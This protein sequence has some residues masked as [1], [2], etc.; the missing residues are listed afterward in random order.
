[1]DNKKIVKV[2]AIVLGSLLI[3]GIGGGMAF[4]GS[5]FDNGYAQG[6]SDFVPKEVI[7]EV[8]VTETVEV[9]VEVEVPTEVFVD[10]GN[11]NLLLEHIYDNDGKINYLLDDLDDDELD[12]IVDRVVFIN[13]IKSLAVQEIKSE[14]ADEVD[15]MV[16]TLS[17]N[18]TITLDEDDVER[19]RVDDDADEILVDDIDFEDKDA[20]LKVTG[21][22]EQDDV[23]FNYEAIVEF[24]DGEVDDIS[25]VEVTERV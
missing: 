1:M 9:P 25:H 23:K 15:K 7:K 19:I 14:I 6:Q 12:L 5:G 4:N 8:T 18:S 10:N 13:D 2:G 11:L 3:G 21:T 20:D 24:K 16:I 17:D 22:F